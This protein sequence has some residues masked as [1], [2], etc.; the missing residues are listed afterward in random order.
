MA[1]ETT[2][3]GGHAASVLPRTSLGAHASSVLA[4][5]TNK[6]KRAN[7]ARK[8]PSPSP[9]LPHH[10]SYNRSAGTAVT[11]LQNSGKFTDVRPFSAVFL[12]HAPR[13]NRDDITAA[14]CAKPTHKEN[15]ALAPVHAW[16]FKPGKHTADKSVWNSGNSGGTH[17][18]LGTCRA[19]SPYALNQKSKAVRVL[20]FKSGKN[21]ASAV[22]GAKNSASSA[23]AHQP[24]RDS[25]PP[26][27]GFRAWQACH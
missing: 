10:Q 21:A 12:A 22:N 13:F 18:P 8:A 16:A 6:S 7:K 19:P 1:T 20:E 3:T 24:N 5:A 2:S 17:T 25:Q 27:M 15:G 9:S 14:N 26:A 11:P 4:P 23:N